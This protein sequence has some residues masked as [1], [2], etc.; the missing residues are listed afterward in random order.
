MRERSDRHITILIY[1]TL[2]V[3]A[4]FAARFWDTITRGMR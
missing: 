3:F 4:A 2:I 1:A